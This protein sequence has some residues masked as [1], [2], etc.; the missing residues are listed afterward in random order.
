MQVVGAHL[1]QLTSLSV[2]ARCC[3]SDG[4]AALPGARLLDGLPALSR[5]TR[6]TSLV[7]TAESGGRRDGGKGGRNSHGALAGDVLRAPPWSAAEAGGP[8]Y[9]AA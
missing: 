9:D 5:L 6:L 8:A 2:V 1:T 7:A 4:W 3:V